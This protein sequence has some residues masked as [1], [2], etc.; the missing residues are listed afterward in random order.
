MRTRDRPPS[1][2]CGTGRFFIGAC[3]SIRSRLVKT[4]DRP[5]V[6]SGLSP[7]VNGIRS[8]QPAYFALVMATGIV[9]IAA[10][11]QGMVIVAKALTGLNVLAFVVLWLLTLARIVFYARDFFSDLIDHPEASGFLRSPPAQPSW[12]PNWWWSLGNMT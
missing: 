4:T 5:D 3:L 1:W 11:L 9:A 12:D 8:L 10:Q 6:K 2:G 7:L